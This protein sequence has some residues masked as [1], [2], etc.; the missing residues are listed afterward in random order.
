MGEMT[1]LADVADM[2]RRLGNDDEL[3]A[4][5]FQ[6][7]LE[8]YPSQ[9]DTLRAAVDSRGPDA[10]RRAAHVVK[11]SAGNLS[12]SRVADAAAALE[13]AAER[14]GV[15]AFD[16]LFAELANQLQALAAELHARRSAQ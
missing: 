2:R 5:L 6:L 8:D 9:L 14:N 3:I 4:E 13:D 12:A 16:E 10:V 15:P 1:V 7:F 11:S